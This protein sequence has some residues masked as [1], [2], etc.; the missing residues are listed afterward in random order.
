M[1]D[2]YMYTVFRLCQQQ[3]FQGRQWNTGA[4]RHGGRET[5]YGSSEPSFSI[6]WTAAV[7]GQVRQEDFSF[8]EATRGNGKQNEVQSAVTPRGEVHTPIV[9]CGLSVCTQYFANVTL[10]TYHSPCPQAYS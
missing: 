5:C 2:T 6:I 8:G 4:P 7:T 9:T 10:S 3:A 1:R